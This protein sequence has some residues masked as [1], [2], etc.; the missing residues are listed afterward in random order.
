[1]VGLTVSRGRF[2][3][4]FT[5]LTRVSRADANRPDLHPALRDIQIRLNAGLILLNIPFALIGGI[6]ALWITGLHLSVAA[7]IGFIA[8]FGVSVQNG[9]PEPSGNM[10]SSTIVSKSRALSAAWSRHTMRPS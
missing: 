8:L 2:R 5:S 10:T 3:R 7:L 9:M 4:L 6:V 1:M